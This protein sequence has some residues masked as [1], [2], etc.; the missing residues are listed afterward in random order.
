MSRHTPRKERWTQ[1][2]AKEYRSA[3]GMVCYK[4]GAWE[5]AVVFE[6]WTEGETPPW[7]PDEEFAGRFKRPRNAMIAVEDKARLILREHGDKVKIA[8]DA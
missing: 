5:G 6:R 7:Q 1:V 4:A 2:S 3:F 8:I